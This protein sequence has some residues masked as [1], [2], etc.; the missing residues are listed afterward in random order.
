MQSTC[1]INTGL[2][3]A[4]GVKS[5]KITYSTTSSQFIISTYTNYYCSS[6]TP[7]T[8][9]LYAYC[10]PYAI[11]NNYYAREIWSFTSTAAPT[12]LPSTVV[13]SRAPTYTAA[14][15]TTVPSAIPSSRKPSSIPSSAAPTFTT[16][17]YAYF[18]SY[19]TPNNCSNSGAIVAI[20]AYP[21]Q[22]CIPVY[23]ISSNTPIYFRKYSCSSSNTLPPLIF[24]YIFP[25][26]CFPFLH[27]ILQM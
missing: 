14:P 12:V 21:L 27:Q 22:T 19:S 15:S 24:N 20:T 5:F 8:T 1:Y 3:S 23:N 25:S 4:S 10:A 7:S 18:N 2:G 17:G 16:Q 13:P 11:G 6:S 26:Y 9:T